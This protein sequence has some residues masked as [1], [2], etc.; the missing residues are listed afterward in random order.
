MNSDR[1]KKGFTLA[2][3]L[4]VVGILLILA[5]VIFVSVFAYLRSMT[6]VEYDGYA[7]EIFV[8]AQNR[9]SMASEEGF[10]GRGKY[11]TEESAGS[12]IYYFIKSAGRDDVDDTASVLNL[13][14]PF[15]AVEES[16]RSSG[17]YIIRYHRDSAQVLDVFYW[18]PE[19]RYAHTYADE[20][21][22]FMANR[23]DK[24]VLKSFG[25]E[26]SVI[27][28]YGGAEAASLT[29]GNELK[30]PGLVLINGNELKISVT[31]NSAGDTDT[32]L[33][34]K[35][36][37]TGLTSNKSREHLIARNSTGIYEDIILDDIKTPNKHF[38]NLFASLNPDWD[39]EDLIPGEDISVQ[40][41]LYNKSKL[42]NVA[43]SAKKVTN[44]L[45]AYNSSD[46]ASAHIENVR[47]LENLDRDV[48]NLDTLNE[49]LKYVA[50]ADS[51][52]AKQVSDIS[53]SGFT[54]GRIYGYDGSAATEHDSVYK[55]VNTSYVLDYDGQLRSVTGLTV[56]TSGNAGMF[57]SLS[58]SEVKN[59]KF[60][61]FSVSG[62]NAGAL[63]G[64][65]T[66]SEI[67]NVI[68]VESTGSDT[69]RVRGI[70]T[71][72]GLAGSVSGSAV[73]KCAA[74]LIV[75]A[76]GHAGGLAGY[77]SSGSFAYCYSAGHTENG[78]YSKTDFNVTGGVTAGGLV[79]SSAG[80]NY[81]VCYSTCSAS[82]ASAGGFAGGFNGGAANYCYVTGLVSGTSETRVF[83][84]GISGGAAFNTCKYY[85]IINESYDELTKGKKYLEPNTAAGETVEAFD[86][87]VES[88][89]S[90]VTSSRKQ[91]TAYDGKLTQ[92]YVGKYG[93]ATVE[94]LG[95]TIGATDFVA[96]HYGDWPAPE[97]YIINE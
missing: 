71:A 17:C 62:G 37:V 39:G 93:F 47:H 14:V 2:E 56:N 87:N 23:E 76:T 15:G 34:L 53:W 69:V 85:E 48:S 74:A 5:A 82:G 75:Q 68:A 78:G 30:A 44:S 67:T 59:L 66:G 94:Q 50:S 46:N 45:F 35:V 84:A 9:L 10:L 58:G 60:V 90:F 32:E 26:K 1:A 38:Y 57:G 51:I 41:V 16:V 11:G 43:S 42:T 33:V 22:E 65:I 27:G 40:A 24:S 92:Y 7:K 97:V 80:T 55:P 73:N 52:K 86:A 4:I 63:A 95:E 72:G 6:K 64:E 91:A 3:V 89:R 25:S 31:D 61:D 54:S 81:S 28:W 29:R 77:A 8:A 19:G 79:G 49:E 88:Y 70:T 13:L 21:A 20:Y 18:E 12:G 83:A 36:I 96:V